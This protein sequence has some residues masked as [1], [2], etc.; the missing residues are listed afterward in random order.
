MGNNVKG[1]KDAGILE[2]SPQQGLPCWREV[3][4]PHPDVAG[5]LYKNAE[6][7]ANLAQVAR[8]EG[9]PEY[10]DPVQFFART[11]I[12]EGMAGLLT[13][14]L[15]RV[16]GKGGGEPVIQLKTAFGGGKTHS[17][18]ALYH[19][20]RGKISADRIPNVG[21]VLES[22]GVSALPRANVAVLVGTALDP[23]KGKRPGDM[24]GIMVNTL[25]GEMAAQ[26][27]Q[28]CGKPELYEIV[29]GAD[30]KGVTPGSDALTDLFDAAA[31][32][33][34]LMDE[35]VPY[36]KKIYGTSGLPA[37]TFDNF[38]TFIQEVTEA[39]GNSKNSLVVASIPE[40]DIEIGGEAGKIALATI[41]HTFGRMETIWKP[42]K[43]S[44]GFEVVRR[45][46]FLDCKNPI[47]RDNVC[48]A[49]S[50]M[51]NENGSEF[52]VEAKELEYKERM[53]SC[54]PIHPEVFERLYEE[55]STL[56]KFQRTRGVLRLM[57]AVIHE[58]WMGNDAGLMIMPGSIPL[59]VPNV[60]DELTRHLPESWNAIVDKEVDGKDSGPF[61]ID[62]NTLYGKQL[63][64][65]RVARTI[66]LGSAPT[67]RGQAVRGI[68]S[69]RVRL[70]VVQP[71]ENIPVFNDALNK[72]R[73]TLSYLYTDSS[74]NRYWYD[75]RPTL[76][77]TAEDRAQQIAESDV[78]HEIETRLHKLKKDS[79]FAG[80]H[81]CPASSLDVPDE[82]CARLV[83]LRPAD[84]YKT[85]NREN[86]AA[87]NVA[88]DILNNR[89]SS[90]RTYRNMLA[91]IAPDHDMM[92]SL[93]QEVR[94][95]LAWKSI[96]NDCVVLNLDMAQNS[97]TKNNISR[98]DGTTDA[99]I[100]E[101]YCWLLVPNIDKTVDI[102][103]IVW[104]PQRISGG[105]ESIIAGA[106]KK[107]DQ[108]ESI[109]TQWAPEPLRLE[110]DILLWL[111]KDN[112]AVAQLWE[113]LC[114][115]CYLPR[116]ADYSV[117]EKAIRAGVERGEFFAFASGFDGSRY[118]GLKFNQY[119][120]NVEPSGY[121]VKVD[122]AKKQLAE[123]RQEQ[124]ESAV[125][126]SFA[127]GYSPAPG[128]D[129]VA[130]REQPS[131]P[132]L[133]NTRFFMSAQLN[134][135]HDMGRD[136]PQLYNEIIRHL[137]SV[138]K[139][140]DVELSLELHVK[141]P[142]GF[143]PQVVQ[144]VSENCRTLKVKQFEFGD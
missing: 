142:D 58:L 23:T 85:N 80:I 129:G 116:L 134:N 94:R 77:K 14:A 51:Y 61:K 67:S 111:D 60:R 71:G 15:L 7:A 18:L 63:A 49:F 20:M 95:F 123:D 62:T 87:M 118:D 133:K 103:T 110:L 93:K 4:E 127:P 41:E 3:I 39:A 144:T 32:C 75:T 125:K 88:N 90:P 8:G 143:P 26:L 126:S 50:R 46:L 13:Q 91:F 27:A 5:G 124:Q 115:Y 137:A 31:P 119:V 29:K 48:A 47:G 106:A 107:M 98:C 96:E 131:P 66:M 84:E 97:E 122:V 1:K 102:K 33:M 10:S 139:A 114:S 42:V 57:A 86:N 120:E 37:G 30:K 65:R 73:D 89:G 128:G 64:A 109:I 44:E 53:A 100:K 70:G 92:A 141:S 11:F 101:A 19:I 130:V 68:E 136:I 36:A 2:V 78:E 35:L 113:Y 25:W 112:I 135:I 105:K 17:M 54:Y 6:F 43:A 140:K 121:L 59:S 83:V 69:S 52:P 9:E 40:S 132:S 12:T 82:Q 138:V 45:R 108:S 38:I 74:S 56:E 72:L 79:P 76:R 81:I 16:C 24:P 55:W 22:A 99:R 117:L 28:S 34:V 21:P 104:D